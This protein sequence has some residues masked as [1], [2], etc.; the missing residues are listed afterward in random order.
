[1]SFIQ[2][3]P[4]LENAFHSDHLLKLLLKL[5]FE[6]AIQSKEKNISLES[7]EEVEND[8]AQFGE[9]VVTDILRLSKKAESNP[10]S[11]DQ[12][13]AW[14]NRIDKINVSDAWRE[15]E[16]I[17]AQEG[18]IAHGYQRK[19]GYLSRL[20]QFFKLYLFHPSSAFFSCPLAM[21]DGAAKLIE[22]LNDEELKQNA[23]RCLTSTNPEVFWTSGQW[24]TEK[25]G[26]SDVGLSETIAKKENGEWYLEGIKWFT[27]ATTSQMA[28]AL[29]RVEENGKKVEGV[30][31]LSLFYIELRDQQDKLKN[32]QILRL[33]DKL[34]TK[35]LPTA[36][37][38]LDKTP[39]K[40][41]GEIGQGVKTISLLFNVTRIYNACTTIGSLRRLLNYAIDYS[42]KRHAFKSKIIDR[43]LHR[44]I[45]SEAETDL[46]A[47]SLLTFYVSELLGIEECGISSDNQ[48]AISKD[49]ASKVLR[50]LTPIAK[51]YTAKLNMK[52][53]SELV[54]S[55][56]GAGYIEDTGIPQFLRDSQVFSIW[57]GTTNVLCLDVLRAITKEDVLAPYNELMKIKLKEK[58]D[59]NS[60]KCEMLLKDLMVSIQNIEPSEY[61]YQARKLSFSIAE[62]TCSILLNELQFHYPKDAK[63]M[64]IAIRYIQKAAPTLFSAPR[65]RH[66]ENKNIIS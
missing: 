3:A 44:E 50:L 26:G 1:M 8:L 34:G 2:T 64:A 32:I 19:Y 15:L 53:T 52:H 12:Y 36:E 56:G 23:Y 17:S 46:W 55:F 5:K 43:P 27:S 42:D 13:D 49:S 16:K 21:T 9:R 57:E 40:L 33:K 30:K 54:E 65:D 4:N 63:C 48:Y 60:K 31:G 6:Q 29:A 47:M 41:V 10:P 7:L 58:D 35:A 14:G 62:V 39:A 66:E 28:M 51:L 61:E 24:M 37:L 59:E 25:T 22:N 20:Y 38:K 11:L 18:I 45:L